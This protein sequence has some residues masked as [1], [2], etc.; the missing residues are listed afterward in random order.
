MTVISKQLDEQKI[1][2]GSGKHIAAN[3]VV[4]SGYDKEAPA[5]IE[6]AVVSKSVSRFRSEVI[7]CRTMSTVWSLQPSVGS[8][9]SKTPS[10][11]LNVA[12]NKALIQAV[13]ADMSSTTSK[14]GT[15]V[16]NM[17]APPV[18]EAL[19]ISRPLVVNSIAPPVGAGLADTMNLSPSTF[20]SSCDP[21]KN[22]GCDLWNFELS[23]NS[24]SVAALDPNPCQIEPDITSTVIRR[25]D[26]DAMFRNHALEEQFDVALGEEKH[27]LI[28]IAPV[29]AVALP[30]GVGSLST[31]APPCGNAPMASIA[32]PVGIAPPCGIA[33]AA[34]F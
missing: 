19:E 14:S 18:G 2:C 12:G 6:N 22:A 16:F 10:R 3:F 34:G 7:R 23:P 8:W 11:C 13:Q 24:T 9:L 32:P 27:S 5:Q 30:H 29:S 15:G 33:P 26:D 25:D 17:I 31:I 20:Q 4:E 28:G 21:S 1:T